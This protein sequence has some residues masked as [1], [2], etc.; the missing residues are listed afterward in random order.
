MN[1]DLTEAEARLMLTRIES[2]EAHGVVTPE[3]RTLKPKLL[4]HLV[5]FD[6]G[7]DVTATVQRNYVDPTGRR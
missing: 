3:D 2:A 4:R 7:A 1:I 5:N 6:R